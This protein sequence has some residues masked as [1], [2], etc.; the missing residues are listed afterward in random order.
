MKFHLQL[1]FPS[2]MNHDTLRI[3]I[4]KVYLQPNVDRPH[5]HFFQ[6]ALREMCI[7]PDDVIYFVHDSASYMAPAAERLINVL[8][9][10]NLVHLPCWAHL[11][12]IVDNVVFDR[13]LLN[14]GKYLRLS[15]LLSFANCQFLS[16]PS[17]HRAIFARSPFWRSKWIEHQTKLIEKR[18]SEGDRLRA[19]FRIACCMSHPQTWQSTSTPEV[20]ID[21]AWH[22]SA[23]EQCI[24]RG[25]VSPR[26]LS[27]CSIIL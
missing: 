17:L 27:I 19:T 16:P 2:Q 25:G 6:Q 1:N 11:T 18:K 8:G 5:I 10:S 14:W 23:L 4:D 22:G 13:K 26:I 21:G 9:Y 20:Q 12:N 24:F 15:R 3:A 7:K